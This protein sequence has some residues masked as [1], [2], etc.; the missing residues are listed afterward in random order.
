VAELVIVV[1]KETLIHLTSP[2]APRRL[3][4]YRF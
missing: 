3:P 1:V 4:R 2:W